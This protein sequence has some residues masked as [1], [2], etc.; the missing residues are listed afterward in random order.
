VTKRKRRINKRK[1]RELR[2]R[3]AL[4]ER[5]VRE[6]QRSAVPAEIVDQARDAFAVIVRNAKPKR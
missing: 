5:L 4:L 3:D 6:L 1:L 2:A